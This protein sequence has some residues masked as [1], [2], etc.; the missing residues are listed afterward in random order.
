MHIGL[1]WA[2]V[3]AA[4]ATTP[5]PAPAE[6]TA[7]LELIKDGTPLGWVYSDPAA[8]ACNISKSSGFGL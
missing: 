5:A 1:V 2:A 6:T 7:P 3:V 4:Q 8:I